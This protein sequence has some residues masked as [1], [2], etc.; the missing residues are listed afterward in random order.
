MPKSSSETR[1]PAAESAASARQRAVRVGHQDV[2]GDLDDEAVG[3]HAVLVERGQHAVGPA[4]LEQVGG[5]DVDRHRQA[6]RPRARHVGRLAQRLADHELGQRADHAGLLGERDEL[7]GRDHAAGR[8]RPAH[9]RLDAGDAV[10]AEVELGLEVQGQAVLGDRVAQLADQLQALAGVQV[11]L[12]RVE[13]GARAARLGLVH[14]DVGALEQRLGV[15]AV[16]RE[17]RDADAGGDLQLDPLDGEALRQRRGD[18]L[19]GARRRRRR[20]AAGRRT[21]RRRGGR[22]GRRSA[23]RCGCAGRAGRARGRRRGGRACR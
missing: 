6:R 14:R 2:L 5:R 22:R 18:P 9:E 10:A 17:Q 21:R 13:L 3:A 15:V 12:A 23:A 19:A 20:R 7:V 16:L 1:T 11:A 8:V 4:V